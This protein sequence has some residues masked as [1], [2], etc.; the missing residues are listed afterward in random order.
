MPRTGEL[1]Q[2]VTLKQPA[3]ANQSGQNVTTYADVDTV[4]AK[5]VTQRGNEAFEAARLNSRRTI[6]V[7]IRYRADVTT[8]WLIVW[9]GQSYNITDRDTSERREGNLWLTAQASEAS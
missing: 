7:R 2:R 8:K 5:V 3:K 4:W 6:R 1:D 9:Q